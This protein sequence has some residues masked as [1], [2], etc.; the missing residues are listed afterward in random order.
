MAMRNTTTATP[1][2]N[3]TQ[4]SSPSGQAWTG[5]FE[6]PTEDAFAQTGSHG[7]QTYRIAV[8]T[9]VAVPAGAQIRIRLSDPGFTSGDGAGPLQIGAASVST[10][11]YQAIPGQT[12]VALTFGSSSSVTLPEGGDVYSNPLTLPFAWNPGTS[13]MISVWLQNSSLTYVPGDA[14]P[15]GASEYVSAYNSGNQTEDT[16]GTPFANSWAGSVS[17]LTA[18]DVTTPSA[19]LAGVTSPGSP[20]VVVAG[21]NVIDGWT[22][23]NKAQTDVLNNPS[24][25]LAGQLASQGLT[26][27]YGVVDAGLIVNQV[28]ADLPIYGGMGLLTRLDRDVLAEPN[29]GTVVIDQG[30][31]DNLLQ[32]GSQT[33]QTN[34]ENA[35]QVLAAELGSFGVNVIIADLTPC[36]GYSSSASSCSTAV[37]TAR[38][39]L[40]SYIDGGPVPPGGSAPPP[41]PADFDLALSNGASPEA[42]QSAFDAGDHVNL[43]LGSSGGY[44]ALAPAVATTGCIAPNITPLPVTP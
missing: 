22:S 14:V 4:A 39:T 29:V 20:T 32:A 28:L 12:P 26:S 8:S 34:L 10:D 3:G 19:I 24:Q 16:T 44:A 42:L 17:V 30:L 23:G 5:A 11:Y 25:R 13:L 35:Y 33:I 31:E 2:V 1:Q 18:V 9:N 37:D 38:Q 36:G 43:T 7:N 15:S 6:A 40:N 41:C 21:D 27:G